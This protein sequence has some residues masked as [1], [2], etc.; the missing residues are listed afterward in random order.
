MFAETD[1]QFTDRIQLVL[2]PNIGPM[3]QQGPLGAFD[4][5]RDLQIYVDGALI[6]VRTF[7]FDA[8]G[9][10]YLLFMDQ[11][12]N[13]QGVIQV[14][15]HMPSP[16]FLSGARPGWL[17]FAKV[18]LA[19]V[20]STTIV[21]PFAKPVGKGNA[22]VVSFDVIPDPPYTLGITDN[23]GNSYALVNS[24]TAAGRRMNTYVAQNSVAGATTI[25]ATITGSAT[26]G[27]AFLLIHEI[28]DVIF[29]GAVDVFAGQSGTSAAPVTP[30]FTTTAN[31]IIF[32]SVLTQLPAT[33][34]G[35]ARNIQS[36][37]GQSPG[38]G[39]LDFNSNGNSV[40]NPTTSLDHLVFGSATGLS[41]LSPYSLSAAG[42]ASGGNTA[43]TG[44]FS[45]GASTVP[46]LNGFSV[47]ISGF[48]NVANNG[49]F[50]VVSTNSTTVVV[51][52]PNG[53]AETAAATMYNSLPTLTSTPAQAGELALTFAVV[54][55]GSPRQPEQT[56]GSTTFVLTS[57]FSG[58]YTFSSYSGYTP[59]P[60][61]QFV[62][63]SGFTIAANNGSSILITGVT[64]NSSGGTIT[65]NN[66]AINETHAGIA[67]TAWVPVLSAISTMWGQ[68]VPAAPTVVQT[69]GDGLGF[70]ISLESGANALAF[71]RIGGLPLGTSGL[72]T[73]YGGRDGAN[74]ASYTLG[75]FQYSSDTTAV[76]VTFEL[77]DA[78]FGFFT[79]PCVYSVTDD[80]G[81]VYTQIISE[82]SGASAN[83]AAQSL[84]FM[85]TAPLTGIS[86]TLTLTQ[87]S[88]PTPNNVG[89]QN[90]VFSVNNLATK[91]TTGTVTPA[92]NQLP[93]WALFVPVE[94]KGKVVPDSPWTLYDTLSGPPAGTG[95]FVQQSAA[96]IVSFSG[97]PWYVSLGAPTTAGNLLFAFAPWD[98]NSTATATITDTTGNTWHQLQHLTGSIGSGRPTASL[99]IW[100]AFSKGGDTT[101][102][103]LTGVSGSTFS[104]SG[105]TGPGI[106]NSANNGLNQVGQSITTSGFVNAGN[107]GLFEIGSWTG[108]A[109]GTFTV[110][111]GSPVNET[112]AG[113]AIANL[114][115]K[116]TTSAGSGSQGALNISEW[117]GFGTVVDVN[118]ETQY[119]STSNPLVSPNAVTN[120][121]NENAIAW[122]FAYHGGGGATGGW[123]LEIN[124]TNNVTAEYFNA[125]ATPG[126]Y[127]VSWASSTDSTLG[128]W[129]GIVTFTNTATTANLY[130]QV[131]S[132]PVSV[133]GSASLTSNADWAALLL[134]FN[135]VSTTL[136]PVEVQH[137]AG[138]VGTWSTPQNI[139]FTNPV[140]AGST[141]IAVFSSTASNGL[142]ASL[143]DN[144]GN[145]YTKYSAS[146]S[147]VELDIW[148]ATKANPGSTT[149][150]LTIGGTAQGAFLSIYEITGGALNI[151]TTSLEQQSV[152]ATY[153][154]GW[155]TPA[156]GPYLANAVALK[157]AL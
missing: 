130:S 93:Q 59:M 56:P 32:G 151:V 76:F 33:A 91:I 108:G 111:N 88:G 101:T 22:I 146:G 110:L 69:Y 142:G 38:L 26:P 79:Q 20:G 36:L 34:T 96:Q 97:S 129:V 70:P 73:F 47:V 72:G 52:N 77:S 5:R 74:A 40:S 85:A 114:C 49:V 145:T 17:Q 143:V 51:A 14:V 60:G 84:V 135:L 127:N 23:L 1:G 46:P 81:N 43:Y 144:Q 119:V 9:N 94:A 122:Q 132:S 18:S 115:V 15:H 121:P 136:P 8:N 113:T 82:F 39:V 19:I 53:V 150:T 21:L 139:S 25:T 37:M 102:F 155:T 157:V 153:H 3:V 99:Y 27:V 124:Q 68:I 147:T 12:I 41:Q 55:Q 64:G 152:P 83:S 133:S 138:P 11:Q 109:S 58:G 125:L 131:V 112:H 7:T 104:Y 117:T 30:S 118:V 71:F 10:R 89:N 148:V 156:S 50:V 106:F 120:F 107:N 128:A 123:A 100:Y 65:T 103:T 86:T 105:F 140:E 126:S 80:Q 134:L 2:D 29:S 116:V 78:G 90:W 137:R 44:T 67:K 87:I 45:G 6:P 42:A 48:T 61:L 35:G 141:I 66:G 54:S 28:T 4:P 92:S 75:P 16:P 63:I 24:V 13:L 95:A 31:D 154:L 149:A 98:T 62:D 57:A